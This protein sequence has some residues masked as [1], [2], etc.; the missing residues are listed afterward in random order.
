M[1]WRLRSQGRGV[2]RKGRLFLLGRAEQGGSLCRVGGPQWSR[3]V[4]VEWA[5][6]GFGGRASQ[7]WESSRR[8]GPEQSEEGVPVQALPGAGVGA[9]AR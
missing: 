5:E 3:E 9:Q 8:G 2:S 7:H 4:R 6:D 1:R